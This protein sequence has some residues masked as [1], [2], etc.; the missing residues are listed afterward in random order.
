MKTSAKPEQDFFFMRRGLQV[1]LSLLSVQFVLGQYLNLYTELPKTHPGTHGSYAPSVPWALAGSAG[2]AL[3]LHVAIWIFLTLGSVAL[4]ILGIMSR[5]KA[6]V[7]AT[8]LGLL[9]ILSA[10]SGGLVFLNQGGEDKESFLMAIG[11]ILAFIAYGLAL[12]KAVA[13]RK[14]R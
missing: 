6:F 5:R 2:I 11:F 7:V 3:A 12:H 4:L 1:I 8:S 9:F 14:E 10:G 13:N